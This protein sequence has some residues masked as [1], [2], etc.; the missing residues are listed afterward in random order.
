[1][2]FV[3]LKSYEPDHSTEWCGF[4]SVLAVVEYRFFA[5]VK[6]MIWCHILTSWHTESP[7][8]IVA[9]IQIYPYPNIW[10][11]AKCYTCYFQWKSLNDIYVLRVQDPS[12]I[13]RHKDY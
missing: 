12:L 7:I 8:S 1:M 13:N 4:Y 11:C 10:H 3:L 2:V 5:L 9:I 6:M